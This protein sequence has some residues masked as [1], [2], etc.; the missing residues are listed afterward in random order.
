MASS[1]SNTS[2]I[3]HNFTPSTIPTTLHSLHHYIQVKL[4]RENYPSWRTQIV[5]YLEG[6]ELYGFVT[7]EMPCPSKFISTIAIAT[8]PSVL[9]PNPDYSAWYHQDKIVLS[10]LISTLT[11]DVLPHVVGV[12]TSREVWVLFEKMFA[13]ESKA[14]LMQTHFQLTTMKKGSLSIAVYFQ[15]IQYLSQIL[16]AAE[17]PIKPSELICYI[18][19]GLTSDFTTRLEPF[20]VE[21][22]YAHLLTFEQRLERNNEV[23]DLSNASI[24]V[25]QRQNS[26][27]S[28]PMSLSCTYYFGWTWT[29]QI[30]WEM[31][32]LPSVHIFQ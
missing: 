20:S 3:S 9:T 15:K 6:N 29:L 16:A 2:T 26:I 21:D 17:D 14:R 7:G 31:E 24:H 8:I 13:S 1:S 18:L 23:S 10:A 19:A 11:E 12:P 22:L 4:S 32:L 27:P 28:K 30:T 25:A 5:P